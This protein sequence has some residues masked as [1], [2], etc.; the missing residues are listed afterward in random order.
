MKERFVK[1]IQERRETI[2]FNDQRMSKG[3]LFND[4]NKILNKIRMDLFEKLKL[5]Q[6]PTIDQAIILIPEEDQ[7]YYIDRALINAAKSDYHYSK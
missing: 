5:K 6:L 2:V 7:N 3:S 1:K 4:N